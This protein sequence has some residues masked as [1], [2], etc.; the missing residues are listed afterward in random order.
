MEKVFKDWTSFLTEMDSLPQKMAGDS[1]KKF[2][3]DLITKTIMYGSET[4]VFTVS[5]L[6]QK[7]YVNNRIEK[8]VEIDMNKDEDNGENFEVVY[9][10][11]KII[12]LDV[13]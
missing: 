9:Y 5:R 12:S 6:S 10:I 13:S 2:Y 1:G 8:Q 4:T 7:L 11:A 3:N